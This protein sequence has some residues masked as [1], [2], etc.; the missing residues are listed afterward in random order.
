L[1]FGVM[2]GFMQP[3]GHVQVLLNIVDFNMGVQR[4]LDA[5]RFNYIKGSGCAFEPGISPSIRQEL[6]NKGHHVVKLD[7]SYCQQF[8]GGQA[9]TVHPQTKALIA[10]LAAT[11]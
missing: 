2:G 6:A 5:P 3:Q 1:P 7:D 8:G 9:I 10:G 4:A 11:D